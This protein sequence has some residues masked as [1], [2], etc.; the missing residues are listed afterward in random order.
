[1]K[2]RMK[3]VRRIVREEYLRGVPEFVLRQATQKYVE[4]IGQHV[5]KHIEMTRVDPGEQREAF[6]AASVILKELEE[7]ANDL[8]EDKLWSFV[9]TV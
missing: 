4:E 2:A 1:M 8:L 9:R 3:D 6:E 7:E 5:K